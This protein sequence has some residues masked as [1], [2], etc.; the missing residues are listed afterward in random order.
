[1]AR[2][3][4]PS[5]VITGTVSIE[6]GDKTYTGSCTIRDR[7]MTV[8]T[9]YGSKQAAVHEVPPGHLEIDGLARF[10][11]HEIIGE[12]IRNGRLKT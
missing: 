5:E 4:K 9:E 1:M 2:K 11:M 8:S 12:A 10:L 7:W 6:A 3:S